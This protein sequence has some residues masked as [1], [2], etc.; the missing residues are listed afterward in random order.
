MT[1]QQLQEKYPTREIKMIPL[2]HLPKYENYG[3]RCVYQWQE[4]SNVRKIENE[5]MSEIF[6]FIKF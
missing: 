2:N 1:Y 6:N 4:F 3:F 5:I